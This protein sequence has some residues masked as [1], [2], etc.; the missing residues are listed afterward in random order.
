MIN[1]EQR[2]VEAFGKLPETDGKKP[3]YRWGNEYHLLKQ[4]EQFQKVTKSPYPLI[5]QLSNEVNPNAA[6]NK[7]K[8]SLSLIIAVRETDTALLNENRWAKSYNNILF[9]VALNIVTLLNKCGIFLWNEEY[10]LTEFPNYGNGK[11]NFTVD[12]WDA[13]RFDTEI[14]ITDYCFTKYIKF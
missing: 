3:T 13:L 5:Y 6:T 10:T 14:T 11:E 4:L 1:K 12:K 9:P 7:A 8:I 2:L